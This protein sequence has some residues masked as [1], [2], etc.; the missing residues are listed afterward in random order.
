MRIDLPQ[1]LERG[2][3]EANQV[4]DHAQVHLRDDV[5]TV[6]KQQ[7]VVL[8]NRARE[9]VFDRHQAEAGLAGN[10]RGENRGK[11]ILRKHADAPPEKLL[12]RLLAEGASLALKGDGCN[13]HTLRISPS[14]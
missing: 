6:L 12:C 8:V 9:R 1:A 10:D 13:G 14:K 11:S 5:Q 7:I 3:W 2:R 4:V